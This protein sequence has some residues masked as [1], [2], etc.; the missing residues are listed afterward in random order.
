MTDPRVVLEGVTK[1]Y[2]PGR[3]RR[4]RRG[5]P[6]HDRSRSAH[7]DRT[8]ALADVDLV[9]TGGEAVGLV[10]D[11]GAGK[12]TLLRLAAGV[13]GPSLGTVRTRGR[14]ASMLELGIGFH[15]D[16]S[17]NDNLRIT[18]GLLGSPVRPGEARWD[19][20]VSFAGIEDAMGHPVKHYSSGMVARLGFSVATHVDADVVLVD[21]VLS[22][23]DVDFQRRSIERLDQLRR[24]GAAVLVA[25]HDLGTL[26]ALCERVVALDHGRIVGDGRSADVVDDYRG[27]ALA[28]PAGADVRIEQLSV[29]PEHAS[30]GDDLVIEL[31]LSTAM[32]LPGATLELRAGFGRATSA[33]AATPTHGDPEAD[34]AVI[35]RATAPLDLDHG[36]G[37]WTV[38]ATVHHQPLPAA[39]YAVEAIVVDA[40][41]HALASAHHRLVVE[42]ER[43]DRLFLDLAP[44]WQVSRGAP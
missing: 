7:P 40:D 28:G 14:V 29:S 18:A 39:D 42:G 35:A 33:F 27:R 21:E 44:S 8:V 1:W 31:I 2:E 6:W 25:S 16:L 43:M 19:E 30:R 11:N 41:G 4:A 9:A 22:V 3:A 12:T 5:L 38:R 13:T 20:I 10:G 15:P 26:S 37:R 34:M 24:G 32:A 17:G 23:G 36:P